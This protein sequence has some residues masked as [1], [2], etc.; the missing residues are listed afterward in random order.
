MELALQ[1]DG[2]GEHLVKAVV[3][4]GD[5][6]E[7]GPELL[8]LQQ[9]LQPQPQGDLDHHAG[10]AGPLADVDLGL[11]PLRHIA[12]LVRRHGD[13]DVR[14]KLRPGVE[15]DPADLGDA[16]LLQL[17]DGLP[18]HGLRHVDE[19]HPAAG[20]Q[21]LQPPQLLPAEGDLDGH[22]LAVDGHVAGQL[23]RGAVGVCGGHE[24]V[25]P[26]QGAH[27]GPVPDREHGDVRH[28]AE[29]ALHV[30]AIGPGSPGIQSDNG[31]GLSFHGASSCLTNFFN[32]FHTLLPD[33]QEAVGENSWHGNCLIPLQKEIRTLL[34]C[35]VK[36]GAFP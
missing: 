29:Q 24:Q 9:V 21:G 15:G 33:L 23:L 1:P 4:G 17:G 34:I 10:G 11:D 2:P 13:A 28:V 18:G 12:H 26:G 31:D 22:G 25:R 14:R 5:G 32:H 8:R 6:L 16:E 19:Q 7:I 30:P 35:T 20:G 27:G 3:A 36:K